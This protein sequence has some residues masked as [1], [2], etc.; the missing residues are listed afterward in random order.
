MAKVRVVK[1]THP[2]T[3]HV[4]FG[5]RLTEVKLPE[6]LPTYEEV[7]DELFGYT[8]VLLGRVDPPVTSPYLTLAEV[9]AAYY[10]RAREIEM[11]IY[12]G[13]QDHSIP[14][15]SVFYKLRTGLLN[16]FI[17]MSKRLYDLGSRRLTQ[18]DLL[19]RQRIDLGEIQ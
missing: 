1:A 14:R 2:R 10:A 17:E 19:T 6:G 8:D 7:L 5:Y 15:G 16:S 11:L 18:E 9:A 3:V 12:Q 13:E 4:Q